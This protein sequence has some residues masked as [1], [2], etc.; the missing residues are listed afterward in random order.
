MKARRIYAI[1]LRQFYLFRDSK[2]RLWQ[3]VVWIIVD[4]LVWGFMSNYLEGVAGRAVNFISVLLGAVLLWDFLIRIMQGM[5]TSFLED[6]W[7][8][9]FLNVFASP[10]LISEYVLGFVATSVA[11]GALSIVVMLAIAISVFG[12][13]VFAY[14]A[15][16]ILF[17]IILF[18]FGIALGLFGL[19][20]V[21]RFGPSAEWFVWPIPALLSP[22]VG[23]FYPIAI[24][25]QWMRFVSHALPPSYVFEGIRT[26]VAGG[27]FPLSLFAIG[28]SLAVVFVVLAYYLFAYVHRQALKTGRIARYSAE[29]VS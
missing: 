13:S 23:V 14:G 17:L 28:T 26:V 25:P 5:T 6:V 7:S 10:I 22:F 27:S 16:I 19:S 11:T 8:R 29:S 1:F 15:A 9:N 12:F 2:N 20:V 3:T 4:V 18:L 24:L 21:L